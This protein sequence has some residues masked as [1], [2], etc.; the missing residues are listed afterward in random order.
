M[1]DLQRF[2]TRGATATGGDR[3]TDDRAGQGQ[4]GGAQPRQQAQPTQGAR[5]DQGRPPGNAAARP[6]PAGPASRSRAPRR[7]HLLV[8]RVDPW[9]VMKFSF[10]VALVLFVVFFVAVA[11]LYSVLSGMGVFD[12][13]ISVV[14]DLS[15]GSDKWDIS[16]WL[17]AK[18]ILGWTAV[19]GAVNVVLLTALATLGGFIYNLVTSL[20]GGVE[21]TL[22]EAE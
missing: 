2:S 7:A 19:L 1:S 17:S 22:S 14:R 15:G 9:S 16:G 6:R 21:V 4:N 3:R 5:Q 20:V 18:T 10:V 8:S 13:L 12:S 11:V